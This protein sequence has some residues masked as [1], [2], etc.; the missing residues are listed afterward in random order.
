MDP[1]DS[2]TL[3]DDCLSDVHMSGDPDVSSL[4]VGLPAEYRCEDM[5]EEVL[6]SWSDVTDL[7]DNNGIKVKRSHNYHTFQYS[8]YFN[9]CVKFL[10]PTLRTP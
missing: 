5:E 10:C 4:T 9:R 8:R 6:Q 1:G 3:S 2:T 7:L